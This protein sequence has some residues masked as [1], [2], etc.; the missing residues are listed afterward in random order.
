[1][2]LQDLN[3]SFGGR[4]RQICYALPSGRFRRERVTRRPADA[5]SVAPE[6]DIQAP[7][8]HCAIALG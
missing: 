2:A 7:L 4:A 6:A 8:L 3:D 5:G 1:M